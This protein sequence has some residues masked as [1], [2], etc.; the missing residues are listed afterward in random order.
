MR[1]VLTCVDIRVFLQRLSQ[2]VC[3]HPCAGVAYH[4]AA[5]VHCQD[6]RHLFFHLRMG[7]CTSHISG[8]NSVFFSSV[9][10]LYML[11]VG[12]FSYTLSERLRFQHS[13]F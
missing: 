13:L 10:G 3:R 12:L 8:K 1:V 2:E 4:S 11:A 9:A 7:L 6:W 5:A